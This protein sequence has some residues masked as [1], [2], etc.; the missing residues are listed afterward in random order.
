MI[1]S[2]EIGRNIRRY[3]AKRGL[4]QERLAEL[5]D[6]S[7]GYVRQLEIGMKTLSLPALFRIA[8]ALGTSAQSLL[9]C[10]EAD[11]ATRVE[12]LMTECTPWEQDVIV[13]IVEAAAGSLRRHRAA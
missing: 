10:A 12:V 8:E 13:D 6:F 2:K 5:A 4:T 7:E 11:S 3:R 9:A 1:D